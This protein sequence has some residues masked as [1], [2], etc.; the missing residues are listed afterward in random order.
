MSRSMPQTAAL[1]EKDI[2]A[3]AVYCYF[4]VNLTVE[5]RLIHNFII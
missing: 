5:K 1:P 3:L 2:S 4:N